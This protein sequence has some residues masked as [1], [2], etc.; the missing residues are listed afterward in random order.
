MVR[1]H[2]HRDPAS[3]VG[4]H[5]I[6]VNMGRDL[7][8]RLIGVWGRVCLRRF[9]PLLRLVAQLRPGA[10]SSLGAEERRR[11]PEEWPLERR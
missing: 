10:A 7:Q 4:G 6:K 11:T 5:V 3:A 9:V 8:E 2:G 1:R